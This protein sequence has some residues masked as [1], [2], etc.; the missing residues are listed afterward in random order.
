MVPLW[1]TKCKVYG[2]T[3]VELENKFFGLQLVTYAAEPERH[4]HTFHKDTYKIS[5]IEFI[6][7]IL[8]GRDSDWFRRSRS[9]SFDVGFNIS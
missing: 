3:T 8:I 5:L 4:S 9:G 7:L 2:G 1:L 6:Q